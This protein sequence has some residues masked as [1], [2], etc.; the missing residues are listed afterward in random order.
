M[1]KYPNF[2]PHELEQ[3]DRLLKMTNQIPGI[4]NG[5]FNKLPFYDNYQRTIQF[6][7]SD[8]KVLVVDDNSISLKVARGLL[9]PYKMHVHVCKKGKDAIKAV[10]SNRYDLVFIDH[11]MPDMDGVEAIRQIRA[12]CNED[13]YYRDIP[14]I[15]LAANAINDT[16]EMFLKYGFNGYLSKP[17]DTAELNSILGKWIPKE[18][19]TTVSVPEKNGSVSSENPAEVNLYIDDVA[20]EN[21][22]PEIQDLD[23]RQGILFTGGAP[24]PYIA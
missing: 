5:S 2:A 1:L 4:L 3:Q 9:L 15:A 18:K 13:P 19:Q 22:N 6:T 17:I 10:R 16:K 14:I 20:A 12:Y 23:T 24:E 11:K 21:G 8:A 7:A